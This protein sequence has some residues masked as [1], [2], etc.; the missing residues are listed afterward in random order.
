MTASWS[1]NDPD[2]LLAQLGAEML[3]GSEQL[4]D[5]I[6]ARITGDL[7]GYAAGAVPLADLR[8]SLGGHVELIFEH[9]GAP[10]DV[11]TSVATGRERAES[12]VPLASLL[13][14][15]RIAAEV[16]WERLAEIATSH[17]L[18]AVTI[19][20]VTS[21][22]WQVLASASDGASVGYHQAVSVRLVERER[23]RAATTSSLLGGTHPGGAWDAFDRLGLPT[24]GGFVVIATRAVEP[25][26]DTQAGIEARLRRAGRPSAWTQEGDVEYGIVHIGD[27]RNGLARLVDLVGDAHHGRYGPVGISPVSGDPATVPRSRQ[28]AH[29]A[30]RGAGRDGVVAFDQHPFAAIT[31]TVSDEG[32]YA[33]E[34]VLAPVRADSTGERLLET[35][36]AW[37]DAHGSMRD[38]A[39]A[40]GCH[41]NTVRYRL[42]RLEALTGRSLASP[43]D[44]AEITVA[45]EVTRRR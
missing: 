26:A 42:G 21:I 16:M 35:F 34:M 14:A 38:A 23:H 39:T 6:T 3:A 27:E 43:R 25:V 32:E 7:P 5:Q 10:V 12:G 45:F 15:F 29:A 36:A 33:A 11:T 24:S 41:V 19:T 28:L 44:V 2:E 18:D 4:V 40:L 30:L 37:L 1:A 8:R 9:F 20:R 17:E 13:A 22:M 31:G